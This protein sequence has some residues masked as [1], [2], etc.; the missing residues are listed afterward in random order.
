MNMEVLADPG[1]NLAAKP[2]FVSVDF[3]YKPTPQLPIIQEL[4]AA[5]SIDLKKPISI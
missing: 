1:M 4:K 3:P 5:K 2:S